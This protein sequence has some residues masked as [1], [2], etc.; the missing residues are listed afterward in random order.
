MESYCVI[1]FKDTKNLLLQ[2]AGR[3]YGTIEKLARVVAYIEA[4]LISNPLIYICTKRVVSLLGFDTFDTLVIVS[5]SH[6]QKTYLSKQ[7]SKSQQ[8]NGTS[9]TLYR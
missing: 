7:T 9:W 2:G 3:G 1:F 6:W 8:Q 5:I 4:K